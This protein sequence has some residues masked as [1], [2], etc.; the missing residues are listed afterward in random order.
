MR[1]QQN[2]G[3][4]AVS[5]CTMVRVKGGGGVFSEA[6]AET[7]LARWWEWGW[8]VERAHWSKVAAE[9]MPP[10]LGGTC[11]CVCDAEYEPLKGS[12][13]PVMMNMSYMNKDSCA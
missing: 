5:V 10:I 2:G 8:G 1:L 9:M 11:V 3:I 13:V 12:H 7:L 6:A 4:V